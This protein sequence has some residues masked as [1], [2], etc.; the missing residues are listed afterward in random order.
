[1]QLMKKSVCN[2]SVACAMLLSALT[3]NYG[4]ADV[5]VNAELEK[6]ASQIVEEITFG[7]NLGNSLDSYGSTAIGSGS[8]S[9]ETSWGNPTTTKE[10]IDLVKDSGINAVRVPVTWYNHMNNDYVIDAAWMNRV[11]EIVNYVIDNDMYC[12]VNVH[13]DTGEKGW[14]KASSNN[15]DQ[16]KAMFTAIW[17]QVSENFAGYGD[18]LLFEGFNEILNDSN[19]WVNPNA[20]AVSITNELNQI[21]V[22]I[23]RKSGGNNSKRN[24]IVTTYCAGGNSQ[25]T[26]GFVLPKDTV[27][28]RLIVDAHIY[29]PFYFT[30][31]FYPE[32][33]TWRKVNLTA[34]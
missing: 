25:V 12:I 26:N 34:I 33:T 9:T 32:V 16:K 4:S 5:T 7:W 31:E 1:M 17:E 27:N 13:H 20:E 19:E 2:L 24:L 14:L 8:L 22:D 15:L 11:E 6:T 10:M 29:Q 3:L 21:F 23:V 28:N 30:S 18:R